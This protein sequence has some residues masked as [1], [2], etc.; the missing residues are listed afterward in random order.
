[1]INLKNCVEFVGDKNNRFV[2]VGRPSQFGKA[3]ER[4]YWS[5]YPDALVGQETTT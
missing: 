1:M 2:A 4:E 5:E 3:K